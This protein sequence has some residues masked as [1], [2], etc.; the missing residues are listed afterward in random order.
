M[1][2]A[3]Y[4]APHLRAGAAGALRLLVSVAVRLLRVLLLRLFL[5]VLLLLLRWDKVSGV[6]GGVRVRSESLA[7][8]VRATR[9]ALLGW[10]A[11]GVTWLA[12][13]KPRRLATTFSRRPL[14]SEAAAGET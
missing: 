14:S 11:A 1:A 8:R 12:V 5:P 7:A 9:E 13:K 3:K 6:G 4:R 10:V 2:L